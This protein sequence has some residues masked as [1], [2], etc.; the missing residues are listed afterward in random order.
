MYP[1]KNAKKCRPGEATNSMIITGI[2]ETMQLCTGSYLLVNQ[3]LHRKKSQ[4]E[5]FKLDNLSCFLNSLPFGPVTLLNIYY[6][7]NDLSAQHS[8]HKTNITFCLSIMTSS[9]PVSS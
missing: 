9:P 5:T 7:L 4:L 8:L 3:Q 6:K 2:S 1:H